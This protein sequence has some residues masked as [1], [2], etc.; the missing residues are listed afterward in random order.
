LRASGKVLTAEVLVV[1]QA[2][3]AALLRRRMGRQLHPGG[4]GG[5][6]FATGS[7]LMKKFRGL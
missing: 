4:I 3:G 5:D 1:T 6:Q 2:A 7:G